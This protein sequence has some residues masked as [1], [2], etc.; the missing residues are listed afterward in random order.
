MNFK[1]NFQLNFSALILI[2]LGILSILFPLV[3]T[4]TIG[5]ISGFMFL[6]VALMLFT[7]AA[8]QM[9]FNKAVGILSILLAIISIIFSWLLLFNPAVISVIASYMIYILGF[10][11]IISGISHLIATWEFKPLRIMGILDVIFGIIYILVGVLVNDPR[12]MG[13][14]IGIWL[15]LMGILSCFTLT[16]QEY[17]D[18]Q[19]SE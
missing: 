10:I 16:R 14:V 11:M 1:R 3:S 18:I 5:I 7:I 6:M 8:G 17:I 4:M 19:K 2:L 13:L 9:V 15:I 12:N